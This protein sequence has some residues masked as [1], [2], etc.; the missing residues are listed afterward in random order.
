RVVRAAA[1]RRAARASGLSAS[2]GARPG[3]ALLGTHLLI[4]EA[5]AATL[6]ASEAFDVLGSF[7][8]AEGLVAARRRRE[9]DLVIVDATGPADPRR[10]S[11][12]QLHA[13]AGPAK[14]LLLADAAD[15]RLQA[16]LDGHVDGM[17][18]T[19]SSVEQL[20]GALHQVLAGQVVLP[21]G[22]R[23]LR[24]RRPAER[25]PDELS[26]RQREILTLVASGYSNEQIALRLFISVNTVKF[27][28]RIAYRTLGVHNRMQAVRL[29]EGADAGD[30]PA[31]D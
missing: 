31:S 29:L 5:L 20:V 28:L 30:L 26:A 11:V 4:V 12:E 1:E 22:W 15:L 10:P 23:A 17:L 25:S 7:T 6:E 9:A 2:P 3:V 24:E 8:V 13:L 21:G 27:H 18:V 19:T 16:V 14:V